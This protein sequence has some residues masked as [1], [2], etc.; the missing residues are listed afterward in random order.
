ML[1]GG[2]VVN[3]RV[4]DVARKINRASSLSPIAIL[5]VLLG[6]ETNLDIGERKFSEVARSGTESL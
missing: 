4:Q 3:L 2:F 5:G 6:D 1:Y